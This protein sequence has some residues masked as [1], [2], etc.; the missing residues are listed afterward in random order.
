MGKKLMMY[1]CCI[2]KKSKIF[3]EKVKLTLTFSCLNCYRLTLIK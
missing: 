1:C 2:I 3:Y